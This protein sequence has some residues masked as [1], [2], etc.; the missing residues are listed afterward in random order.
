MSGSRMQEPVALPPALCSHCGRTIWIAPNL[1]IA[2]LAARIRARYRLR[3]P[4]AL[5]A[6]TAAH[7][8]ATGL[9]TNDAVFERVEGVQ[10]L[11]MDHL[12]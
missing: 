3:T 6:A 5:P 4:D 1:E 7:S 10:T 2:D 9:I 12:L 8:Q 11:V